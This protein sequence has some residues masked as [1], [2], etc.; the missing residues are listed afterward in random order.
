MSVIFTFV[1]LIASLNVALVDIPIT[2]IEH[3][4]TGC[5]TWTLFV[6]SH[7]S[8][9]IECVSVDGSIVIRGGIDHSIKLLVMISDTIVL[10]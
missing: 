3:H 8:D 5:E 2:L 10:A 9:V 6:L 1:S 4:V 7:R